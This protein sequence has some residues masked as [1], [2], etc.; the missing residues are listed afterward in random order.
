MSQ[1]LYKEQGSRFISFAYPVTAEHEIAQI[2]SQLKKEYHD[3]R[4][5]CYAWRIDPCH[6]KTRANDDGEPSFSAGKPILGQILS[7]DLMNI[8]IVVVRYFGGI[9]LG[10]PGLIHAYKT[11]AADAIEN[12]TIVEKTVDALFSVTF[13]YPETDRVMRIAR[14]FNARI[15]SQSFDNTCVM[16]LSV[17]RSLEQPFGSKL[18]EVN[19]SGVSFIRYI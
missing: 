18:E 15:V 3:A 9:K 4:H 10:V 14:D 7:Y 12:N 17:R 19:G 13:P 8:L 16:E 2:V 6:E 1:G 11:A 5:H